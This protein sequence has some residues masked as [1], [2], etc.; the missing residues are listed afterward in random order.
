MSHPSRGYVS[1]TYDDG[2]P[3]HLDVVMPDLESRG[4][5]GTFYVPT[6]GDGGTFDSWHARPTDWAAAANRGHEIANHTR[7]HPCRLPGWTGDRDLRNYTLDRICREMTDADAELDA[8]VGRRPRSFAYPCCNTAVGPDESAE[9]YVPFVANRF[10]AARVGGDATA[11]PMAV[12]L[13]LIPSFLV[14]DHTPF[15]RLLAAVDDAATGG[16]WVV[17]TFHG[18][19]GGHPLDLKR[20]AHA[21]LCDAIAARGP[22]LACRPLAEVAQHVRAA[23]ASRPE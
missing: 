22:A 8:V 15:A 16:R 9:S 3:Q 10:V 1:L 5:R 11:D 14:T 7:R 13:A 23:R 20:D 19:G 12:D 18:V 21:A 4:L 6:G 2:I 17:F